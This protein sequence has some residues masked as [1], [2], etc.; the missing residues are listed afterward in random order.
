MPQKI[1]SR[2]NNKGFRGTRRRRN[3]GL[4]INL[5]RTRHQ[6]YNKHRIPCKT[7]QN[8][9]MLLQNNI[10]Q[11]N[12]LNNKQERRAILSRS[13]SVFLTHHAWILQSHPVVGYL[14]PPPHP[15]I[16]LAP[17]LSYPT[18][19]PFMTTATK[20]FSSINNPKLPSVVTAS[21]DTLTI[22]FRF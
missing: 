12:T 21:N 17:M 3:W 5:S 16:A 11:V 15:H 14:Y 8:I 20:K 7:K 2:K 1:Q 22:Y 10:I 4:T 18:E 19:L 6:S 9:S 13:G